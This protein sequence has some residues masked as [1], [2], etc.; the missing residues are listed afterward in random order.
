MERR[1]VV[2]DVYA[3]IK[4]GVIPCSYDRNEKMFIF[5]EIE[6]NGKNGK[7][8]W[9]IV[10]Y[11]YNIKKNRRTKIT[12]T[13]LQSPVEA[14]STEIIGRY[15]V[16][17]TT[18]LGNIR[19]GDIT[20]VTEGKNIGKSN[21]TTAV[22][23]AIIMA[24]SLYQKQMQV[25]S[26]DEDRP[27]PMLIKAVGDT[28]DAT[29]STRDFDSGLVVQQ[30]LDGIRVLAHIIKGNLVEM[31]SRRGLGYTGL[32]KIDRDIGTLLL[33]QNVIPP[34]DIYLDGEL[35]RHGLPLQDISGI[36]RGSDDEK[37][38]QLKF[39]IFDCY[40]PSKPHMLQSERL[41]L[42][43][44]LFGRRQFEYIERL[45]TYSVNSMEDIENRFREFT[46]Q[47]YEG[48]VIRRLDRVYVEG[49]SNYHT[50]NVLKYKKKG[51]SEYLIVDFK[52]G[53]KGKDLNAVIFI[54]KTPTGATFS[55]VPNW[56]LD[57]RKE[58]FKSL[59]D[60]KD[61]FEQKYKNK[62][63]TVEYSILSKSGVPSQPK[64]IAVRDYE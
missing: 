44:A 48:L 11:A 62:M 19:D 22:G 34:K 31:Y 7:S 26:P 59:Q 23:Q 50:S 5:P 63:A 21:E 4:D 47:N 9:Q 6:I 8:K 18:T 43:Q 60:N 24:N 15:E 28:K 61:L 46:G 64:M 17:S 12:N 41:D 49:K 33:Q 30:K 25:S 51:S 3:A 1:A 32:N 39:Y 2:T 55:A 10:A 36:V 53:I 14:L 54:L 42:L 16:I 52:S 29:L 57:Q 35:Y 20:D 40:V 58:I 37:K 56:S 38:E 13:M 27:L 45:Q